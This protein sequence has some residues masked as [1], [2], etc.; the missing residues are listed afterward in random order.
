MKPYEYIPPPA[1]ALL[2]PAVLRTRQESPYVDLLSLVFW[3]AIACL[4]IFTSKTAYGQLLGLFPAALPFLPP[5]FQYWEER[6]NQRQIQFLKTYTFPSL[7]EERVKERYPH[8]SAEQLSLVT[9]GLRQFFLLSKTSGRPLSMP[10]RVVDAA[11]HEFILLT[12]EYADFCREGMGRFL[13]HTPNESIHSICNNGGRNGRNIWQLACDWEGI[14]AW[15]PSQLP[16]LFQIDTL[17]NIPDGIT[18]SL[19]A[20]EEEMNFQCATGY[21]S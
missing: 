3:T 18:H 7:I 9:L 14:N 2:A 19:D 13:H 11:W 10:S 12:R 20:Y 6:A 5:L 1:E 15:S 16:F 21:L 4:V 8:L 17:L